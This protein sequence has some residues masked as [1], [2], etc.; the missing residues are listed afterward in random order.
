MNINVLIGN[1]KTLYFAYMLLKDELL[2]IQTLDKSKKIGPNDFEL[3]S[4][5]NTCCSYY[6]A[7]HHEE[8]ATITYMSELKLDVFT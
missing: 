6:F 1:A 7:W 4:L 3:M 8:G 5:D 2:L